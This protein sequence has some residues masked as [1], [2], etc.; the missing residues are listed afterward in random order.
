ME[1]ID[2]L[3]NFDKLVTIILKMFL[4]GLVVILMICLVMPDAEAYIIPET[5]QEEVLIEVLCIPN[6]LTEIECAELL[7]LIINQ[8]QTAPFINNTTNNI[9]NN[10]TETIYINTTYNIT[11][12]IIN[13]ITETRI[14]DADLTQFYDR[15]DIDMMLFDF[16]KDIFQEQEDTLT[17]FQ[18]DILNQQKELLYEVQQSIKSSINT[19]LTQPAV[20]SSGGFSAMSDMIPQIIQF[21]YLS[22]KPEQ[23]HFLLNLQL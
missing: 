13:N 14:M 9:T 15:L 19:T 20:Q 3:N 21:H 12:E 7:D 11:N 5:S 23:N 16:E 4:V 22:K 6:N 2:N 8:N 18:Y 10:F 17:N 1:E